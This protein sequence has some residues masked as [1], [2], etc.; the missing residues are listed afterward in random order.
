MWAH[1]TRGHFPHETESPWPCHF[2]P[3]H[4]CGKGE[5]VQ[6]RCFTLRWRDQWS[7]WMQ[8][9]CKSLHEILHGIEWI[10]FHGHLE[11][12]QKPPTGDHGT[13]HVHNRQFIIFYHVWGPPWVKVHWYSIWL[14]VLSHI[15]SHDI[16]GSVTTLHDFGGYRMLGRHLDTFFWALTI[17]GSWLLAH[18]WSGPHYCNS[19]AH[20]DFWA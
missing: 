6:V 11:Y 17:S 15:T 4:W 8:D 9:G 1:Q 2:K 20:G 13:P 14:R 12:F 16:W 3:S 18:V 19:R 7:M 5:P 10:M